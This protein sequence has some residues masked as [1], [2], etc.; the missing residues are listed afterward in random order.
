MSRQ[1]GIWT[2]TDEEFLAELRRAFVGGFNVSAQGWNG[3]FPYD[4]NEE[5]IDKH[6]DV[7]FEKW[8]KGG[9]G[10]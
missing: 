4:N 10:A 6:L 3:E 8:S 2:M 1:D 9:H 7:H 5:Q